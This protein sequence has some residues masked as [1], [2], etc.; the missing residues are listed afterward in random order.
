MTASRDPD[1]LIH[2]FL[3]EG[4]DE[5]P[6]PVY[7]VVRDRIEQTRHRTFI[8]PW[9]TSD[10]NRYLKVGLA[11]AAVVVVAVI[12]YQ[13][14]GNSNTGGPGAT[15]TPQP[16]ATPEPLS[17]AAAELPVGS[18]HVLWDYAEGG[19][20]IVVTIP[21]AGWFGN[22]GG[23]VLKKNDSAGAPDG[24]EVTVFAMTNYGV[25][26]TGDVFVYGDPCHW[27]NPTPR[28][29]VT[30]VDEAIAALSAQPSRDASAP[31]DVTYD[32]YAG[33]RITLH[34]PNDAV[35]SACDEGQFRTLASWSAKGWWSV[36]RVEDPGQFDLF[37]VLDVNGQ[38]VIFDLAHFEGAE[39]TPASVLDEMAG[40][41][42]SAILQSYDP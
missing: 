18:S 15:E 2:A 3:D 10:M 32:G 27:A 35:F 1:R 20:K 13:F 41:M 33:K 29:R 5:L 7:D 25:V 17:S 11:A 42:E 19:M 40:I 24:A 30:T 38:L 36:A 8:G 16:T 22:A 12:G 37:T 14:L 9:R 26:G 28:T 31:E 39:G 4:L 34:V 23:G 6:D 21:A